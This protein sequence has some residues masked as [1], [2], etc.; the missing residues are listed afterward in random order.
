MTKGLT[1]RT[2]PTDSWPSPVGSVS[3]S[4]CSNP[5]PINACRIN[6]PILRLPVD[7]YS[8]Y[9]STSPIRKEKSIITRR[10]IKPAESLILAEH[11]L[12]TRIVNLS[13]RQPT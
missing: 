12:I 4:N 9:D 2:I 13:V 3:V 8:N 5:S 6:T 10:Q 1:T 11:V 7:N